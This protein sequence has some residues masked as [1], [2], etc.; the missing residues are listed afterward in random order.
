MYEEVSIAHFPIQ[1]TIY[2]LVTWVLNNKLL[3]SCATRQGKLI[4]VSFMAVLCL[5]HEL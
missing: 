5:V 4:R 2:N 3:G 1:G